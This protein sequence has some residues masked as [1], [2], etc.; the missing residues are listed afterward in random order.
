MHPGEDGRGDPSKPQ[1]YQ[2]QQQ[3]LVCVPCGMETE[4]H[5]ERDKEQEQLRASHIGQQ[6]FLAELEWRVSLLAPRPSLGRYLQCW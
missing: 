5:D 3:R 4:D 1:G 6:P 2:T